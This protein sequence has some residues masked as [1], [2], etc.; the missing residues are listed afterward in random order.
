[1]RP[2]ALLFAHPTLIPLT[3]TRFQ[4][5]KC[6]TF[7]HHGGRGEEREHIQ[8]VKCLKENFPVNSNVILLTRKGT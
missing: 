8:I 2:Q 6:L 3:Y 7:S 5:G 4:S 1:M